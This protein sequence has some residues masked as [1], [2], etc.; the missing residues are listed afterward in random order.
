M[1][2]AKEVA[3]V[4]RLPLVSVWAGARNGTL[5][6]VRIGRRVRFPRAAIEAIADGRVPKEDAD[7]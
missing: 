2:D 7:G 5:P 3:G 4:L 6:A 1:L